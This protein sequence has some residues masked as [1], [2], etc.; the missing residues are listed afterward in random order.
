MV[1]TTFMQTIKKLHGN[2]NIIVNDRDPI[3]TQN[4]LM[5]LFSYVGTQLAHSPSYHPQSDGKNK[6]IKNLWKDSFVALYLIKK[7]NM[8]SDFL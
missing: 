2:L 7:H 4:F 1:S 6:T 8:S 3:F 5:E